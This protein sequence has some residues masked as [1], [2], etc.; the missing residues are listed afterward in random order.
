MSL[1]Y[2]ENAADICLVDDTEFEAAATA[3]ALNEAISLSEVLSSIKQLKPG[4]GSG[5]V[6][7]RAEFLIQATL[8][9]HGAVVLSVP[10]TKV[11][12]CRALAIFCGIVLI[13]TMY[14]LFLINLN[15]RLYKWEEENSKLDEALVGFRSGYSVVDN[16]FSLSACV[17][18]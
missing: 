6:S 17:Q 13:N 5:P 18:K 1:L 15:N 2:C 12:Q 4:K 11:A 7:I 10:C 14:K 16:I 3:N 9:R 8:S